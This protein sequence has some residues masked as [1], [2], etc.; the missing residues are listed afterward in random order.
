[1]QFQWTRLS[2]DDGHY[3]FGYY[4]RCP[5]DNG[6]RYH[7]ALKVDQCERLPLPGEKAEIGLLDRENPG[8]FEKL[9]ETRAWCHQQ[10]SMTLFLPNRP[11]CFIYN[12]IDESGRVVTRVFE[13]GKG[14][15]DTIH[16]AVYAISPDGKHAVSLN[17]ARIPRRGYSYAEACLSPDRHPDP[18][19]EGI[20][21][22]DLETFESHL[23]V[24][25]RQMIELHPCAYELEDLYLWL[26]HA[27]FNCDST[28][29]LW[30]FRQCPDEHAPR[31]KTFMYTANLDGSELRCPLPD[32][33][34]KGMISHQI[35]GRTPN[36]ILIDANWSGKGSEY[37][38]F[39]ERFLPLRAQ[40][41]STGQGPM[42][43]LIFSPDGKTMLADTYPAG[44][45]YQ[46]LALVDSAT[47]KMVELGK[48][49]HVQPP[50]TIGDA[51]CDLH[52]RWSR[53]GR[54]VTVDS[55]ND[56]RR[57]VYLLELP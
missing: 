55:I 52:P 15:V 3:F 42:G 48:F 4:D 22:I 43:H 36:E 56:G 44:T 20:T 17:F 50:G 30:L 28:K 37:L 10:G 49:R 38:V 34:W 51:R 2:P 46:H 12:D 8:K 11:G 1:M 45:E 41:I 6:G 40:R 25:Y 7:L 14:M 31:W 23:I 53:D 5:W 13:I 24:S 29:L 9:T 18:D 39:D 54:F 27:I 16:P 21:L 33:Y 26:N 35:W 32:F 47:G 57:G 19:R